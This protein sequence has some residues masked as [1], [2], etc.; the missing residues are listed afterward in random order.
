AK[1]RLG[2]ICDRK[3]ILQVLGNLLDNALKFTPE[4]GRITVGAMR[5]GTFVR[6]EVTDSGPGIKPEL[7]PHVFCRYW[8]GAE[9]A[10]AGLGLFIAQGIVRAHGGRLSLHSEPGHGTTF[11]LTLPALDD[12]APVLDRRPRVDA[13][14]FRLS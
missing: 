11:F 2:V 8:S 13:E 6:V 4:G 12:S 10:G 7:Q 14:R 9:R 5:V 3:R 1:G